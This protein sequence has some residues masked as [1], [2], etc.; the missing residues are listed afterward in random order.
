[1]E[2]PGSP[3]PSAAFTA[4]FEKNADPGGFMPFD[5]FMALALYGEG[6]GYYRRTGPRVGFGRG[7]DFFTATSTGPVFGELIVAACVSLMGDGAARAAS[8]VEIGAEPGG[9][10][11]A[12]V[13]HPFAGAR[14]IS[15]G[16][17]LALSGPCIVFS[18]ELFDAQ[19][20]RRLG[21]RGGSWRELGVALRAGRLEEVE[22]GPVLA[23]VPPLPEGAPE[24]AV[25]DAPVGASA[26]M[27]R[28]ASQPW[29]GLIVVCDYGK[30]W[31]ELAGEHPEGTLRAYHRHRQSNDL[32]ARPGEQDL[33]CHVCW[34]WLAGA[35]ET[36]GF[37]KPRLEAQESFLVRHAGAAIAGISAAE[38]PRHSARKG[39]LMQ[40]IHP[41][42]MGRQFQV[43]H[44]LREKIPLPRGGPAP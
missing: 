23:P 29:S 43:L 3:G 12:G 17:P 36:G 33:T 34:D 8:F 7:T 28:I 26:L 25:V 19:P 37:G 11:L 31:A 6:V 44:A 15:L 4:V 22:L 21:F 18:N 38:A 32:L 9:G 42:A 20:C 16:E 24:G 35:L 1:M 14:S 10:V 5:R 39:A 30:S 13:S 27:E 2:S 41:G 40:L